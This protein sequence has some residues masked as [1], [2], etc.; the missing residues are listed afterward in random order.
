M[1]RSCSK[2]RD[3]I[4]QKKKM[5]YLKNKVVYFLVVIFT[6]QLRRVKIVEAA[7]R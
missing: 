1:L 6:F 5:R 2:N 7:G 3:L 4:G